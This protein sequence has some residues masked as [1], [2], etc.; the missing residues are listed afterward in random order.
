MGIT[1]SIQYELF[2]HRTGTRSFNIWLLT[3]M[4]KN[5]LYIC[6]VDDSIGVFLCILYSDGHYLFIYPTVPEVEL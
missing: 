4:I 5:C 1:K 6:N 2:R 3:G